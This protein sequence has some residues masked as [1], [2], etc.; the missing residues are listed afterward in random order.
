MKC[1]CNDVTETVIGSLRCLH[2]SEIL[3]LLLCFK[4]EVTKQQK[5]LVD[6]VFRS[7]LFE[8]R[9]QIKQTVR[10]HPRSAPFKQHLGANRLQITY[11]NMCPLGQLPSSLSFEEHKHIVQWTSASCWTVIRTIAVLNAAGRQMASRLRGNSSGPLIK[12]FH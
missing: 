6:L 11:T 4:T 3:V 9:Y 2:W 10:G 1:P 8:L 7:L 5:L 12:R